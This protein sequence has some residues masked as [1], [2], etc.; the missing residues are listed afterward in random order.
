MPRVVGGDDHEGVLVVEAVLP[1]L[2]E[3]APPDIVL[4]DVMMPRMDGYEVC[5]KM[6]DDEATRFIPIVMVTARA[7]TR[8]AFGRITLP[9][10]LARLVLL[11]QVY[12]G[13]TLLRGHPYHR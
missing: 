4:L 11:E 3:E 2:V 8:V 5:Q 10:E 7:D 9:H 6:K 1:E 13:Y 12:R